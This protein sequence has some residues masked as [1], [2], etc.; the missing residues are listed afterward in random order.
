LGE[1]SFGIEHKVR[2]YSVEMEAPTR[3]VDHFELAIPQGYKVDD[4]PDGLDLDVGFA[5][6]HSKYEVVGDKIQ[7]WRQY[8]LKDIVV[9]AE[10]IGVL[11]NL[12]GR[13]GA[14]EQAVVILKRAE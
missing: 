11:R 4:L 14:D 3:E 5:T 7:Y 12:E 8:D 10:K 2:H 13:I 9:P 6:Y 1:K